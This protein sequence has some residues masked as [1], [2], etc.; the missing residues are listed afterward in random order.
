MRFRFELTGEAYSKHKEAF[1]R[2]L[3]KHGL[4]WQGTLDHPL[5][6]SRAERVSAAYER[7]EAHD[8][9]RGAALVW[10][11][12]KKS[13]LLEDLKAWAWEVGGRVEEEA[14]PAADDVTEEVERALRFWDIVHKPN[15]DWLAAQGRPKAWIDEDLKRWKRQR[16]ARQRELMG[17][18]TD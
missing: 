10:Q 5:W 17:Q 13:G 15:V 2:I 8:V 18:A 9:L 6:T 3:A 14:G 16:Q 4:R 12:A 11:G 7:D 1:K